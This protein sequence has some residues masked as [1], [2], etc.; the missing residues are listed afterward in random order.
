MTQV[1]YSDDKEAKWTIKAKKPYYG[2]KIHIGIDSNLGF[3]TTG[4]TTSA[5]IHDSKEFFK[6]VENMKLKKNAYVL[7]DKGY[8]SKT[9]RTF[10]NNK[11]YQDGIMFKANSGKKLK[12]FQKVKNHLIGKKRSVIE[13]VFGTFKRLYGFVRSRYLGILK[14]NG[15]LLLSSIVFNLKKA[16]RFVT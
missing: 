15:Q 13:G 12:N 8:S 9:N 4:H 2:F 1:A 5:N 11:H 14:T 7:A 6:L 10:L 3:I 16:S